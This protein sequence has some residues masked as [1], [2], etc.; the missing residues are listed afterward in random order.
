MSQAK[1]DRRTDKNIASLQPDFADRVKRWLAA[2][3]S[4]GL[5]PAGP[6]WS[7]EHSGAAVNCTKHLSRAKVG[8]LVRFV[9]RI[10]RNYTFSPSLENYF[11]KRMAF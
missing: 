10:D 1:Y 2:C 4:Q 7:E 8:A 9:F 5:N 6:L 11:T 3:R